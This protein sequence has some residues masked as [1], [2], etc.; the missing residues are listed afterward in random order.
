MPTKEELMEQATEL[1]I[2]GRSAMNK[3]ELAKAVAEAGG[4][5]SEN[6]ARGDAWTHEAEQA[7]RGRPNGL[8]YR[9]GR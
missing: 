2:E 5:V 7:A 3:S 4:S 8:R 9:E 1:D 6:G